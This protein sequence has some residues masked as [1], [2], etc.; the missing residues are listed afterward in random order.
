MRVLA[1]VDGS[2][3]SLLAAEYGALLA[4]TVG[5]QLLL[6]HVLEG[7][8]SPRT[9]ILP[10]DL[11]PERRQVAEDVL[12]LAQS[13]VSWFTGP[14]ETRILAGEPAE[15]ILAEAEAESCD[16]LTMGSRGLGGGALVRLLVGSVALRVL[17]GDPPPVLLASETI[18]DPARRP[19]LRSLLV[20]TDGSRASFAA[21]EFAAT[22]AQAANVR[23][24][25]LHCEESLVP[26]GFAALALSEEERARLAAG[27]ESL[28][29]LILHTTQAPFLRRRL[30]VDLMETRG[31][32]AATILTVAKETNASLIVMGS[33]GAGESWLKRQ[34]LGSVAEGVLAGAHCPVV[35]CKRP[36]P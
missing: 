6:T 3:G 29:R 27:Q 32:P 17:G 33:Y 1:A 22:V 9:R 7:L 14:V 30:A 20:P 35:V 2:R 15:V 11:S 12:A 4:A 13:Q 26:E 5:G 23:V 31:T 36:L 24:L 21:A 28:G 16:L 18:A 8:P 19:E 34:R 25:L 10:A